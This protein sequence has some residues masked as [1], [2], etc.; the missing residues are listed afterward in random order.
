[1]HSSSSPHI[2][3]TPQEFEHYITVYV[4]ILSSNNITV[5][6]IAYYG[7]KCY[8]LHRNKISEK[9]EAQAKSRLYF[10]SSKGRGGVR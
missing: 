9:F 10:T 4:D 3:L 8:V 5:K 2:Y 7:S 1:M 6:V